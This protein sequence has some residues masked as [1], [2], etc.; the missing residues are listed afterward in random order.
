[1]AFDKLIDARIAEYK[2][3]DVN[4]ADEL[5][6]EASEIDFPEGF[7]YDSDFLYLWIR[8]VSAGEFYG[9][10]KNAD[11]FPESELMESFETF[12]DAHPFKNHENKNVENAIGKIISVRWNPVM[13][14][15]ELLKAIDKKRAPEVARGYEK[16]YLTDVSMGCKVPYTVCSICGN[17]A[18]KK[19][20]FCDHVKYYR[21]QLMSTGERVYEINYKPRF[22]DSSTVLNGAERVAKAFFIISSPPENTIVSSFRKSA[23][24]GKSSHYLPISEYEMDKVAAYRE[25]IH[26]L[27]K[28][29]SEADSDT[30]SSPMM[31]K[32]AELEKELTGK[33]LNIVSQPDSEELPKL[34]Q[35]L[36]VIKFLTEKRMDEESLINIANSVKEVAKENGVPLTRAFT[37]LI[38]VAELMGIEFFPTELH[39]LLTN[40]TDGRLNNNFRPGTS[41]DAPVYPSDY[42]NGMS[43]A[44]SFFDTGKELSDPSSLLGLYDEAA[45]RTSDFV[46]NPQSFISSLLDGDELSQ[47]PPVRMIRVIRKTLDPLSS[48]RSYQP[49]H[50]YPRMS[51]L[52]SGQS[53]L[54]GGEAVRK[55]LD[56][57]TSPTS[58]GDLL[59]GLAYGMY[60]KMRPGLA[61]TRII[62]VASESMD[63]L[64][65]TA[66]D[67]PAWKLAVA[68]V[69]LAYGASAFQKSR[70]DNG[71]Y[72][73]D[74]EN[75][76]ADSPGYIAGGALLASKPA[77]KGIKAASQAIG[78]KKDQINDVVEK[79][80]KPFRKESHTQFEGIVKSSE[81]FNSG[82]FNV[83]QDHD[84]LKKYASV[85]GATA[86]QASAVKMATL[87]S[88]GGMEKEAHEIMSYYD[89]PNHEKGRMLK[90]AAVY[91]DDEMSK[92]AE[93]FTNNMILSVVGDHAPLG[94]TL[95]GRAVDSFI[96]KKLGDIG[97]EDEK[98]KKKPDIE[99]PSSTT[100]WSESYRQGPAL[101]TQKGESN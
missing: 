55:D 98:K 45:H 4:T 5:V 86:E 13:K 36:E 53:P 38:G 56:M 10:N 90:V 50:L 89:I 32:I 12:H 31:R 61:G 58:L 95:P 22:H 62:K 87:L 42:T 3:F 60:E 16:G 7:T 17:K 84:V 37:T 85:T 66:A 81:T 2:I 57:L 80:K 93:D 49:E 9:S 24:T 92:A 94:R 29:A 1:M 73:S 83:F 71:R 100:P 18:R 99:T 75:F 77:S 69:P 41:S 54:I 8:I 82:D 43:K 34:N 11:Y 35:M 15:V 97:T 46:G 47:R 33:L 76:V 20:E 65:K 51:V 72:L 39:T 88:L 40:L 78:R 14:C 63:G 27:L 28:E 26:P 21:N 23:S 25:T 68:G 52:L 70:R 6:K 59:G 19:S 79:V 67:I 96:F 44:V 101:Q 74:A 48:I 64:S 30:L 91:M